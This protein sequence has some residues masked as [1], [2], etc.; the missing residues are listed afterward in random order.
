MLFTSNIFISV[1]LPSFIFLYFLL[2]QRYVKP[3]NLLLIIFSVIFYGWGGVKYLGLMGASIAVN[4][5]SGLLVEKR[6]IPGIAAASSGDSSVPMTVSDRNKT[7]EASAAKHVD[8]KAPAPKR[9]ESKTLTTKCGRLK[10][11]A[12]ECGDL[13]GNDFFRKAALIASILVNAA[14]LGVFKYAGFVTQ[15]LADIGLAVNAVSIALPIGISFYTF[16]GMSY[17]FDVY[18]GDT[19]AAK[20]PLTVALYVALFPQLVAGPIV[21]YTD[22][23]REIISRR[24]RL[25]DFYYGALRFML[26]FGKKIILANSVS[27]IADEAF[28]NVGTQLLTPSLA[29]LGAISFTLQIYFDFSAYSDMAIGLGRM[30]GFHFNENFNYPYISTSITEFWRRWH[31]S[32]SSWFRD[33]IYIPLGGNRCTI[34]R[35]ILNLFTVWLLT[36]IWHGANWTYILWGIYYG[37]LQIIEK[38]IISDDNLKKIPMWIRYIT[39][40]LLVIFGWVLFRAESISDAWTYLG[41]M[42]GINPAAAGAV[43]SATA[44]GSSAAGVVGSGSTALQSSLSECVYLIREYYPELIMSVAAS[45][46]IIKLIEDKMTK[47]R[48]GI[49]AF[50]IIISLFALAVFAVAYVKLVS[51]SFSPFIYF[52]F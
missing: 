45:F 47:T 23:E 32:L 50:R 16:Q 27:I 6:S 24:V 12:S 25:H 19:K 36:G 41:C 31:I 9:G 20:N 18:K 5:I 33:Y 26:G 38:F 40:M 51:G 46:P 28:S 3:H 13:H 10:A 35:Q 30:I 7:S 52:Q 8:S 43:G 34:P 2:P 4:Y 44:A 22:I 39:T 1:F 49:H 17:V 14:L 42:F 48:M 29:W 11:L 21:R 37:I 15:T